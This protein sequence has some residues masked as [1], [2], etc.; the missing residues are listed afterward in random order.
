MSYLDIDHANPGEIVSH[1]LTEL[2]G[3]GTLLS[4]S[5]HEIV[6]AWLS[7]TR[8]LDQLLA[9]LSELAPAYFQ[10]NPKPRTLKGL[11]RQV[12]SRLSRLR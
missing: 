3:R 7:A 8:D 10:Q 12:L 4:Y 6:G 2:A 5:D 1:Y 11:K 9:I